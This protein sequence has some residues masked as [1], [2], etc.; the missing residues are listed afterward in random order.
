MR[1]LSIT[2]KNLHSLKGL[3]EIDLTR[4]SF[5]ESG[6]FLITGPTGAGK[7]T[8]LDALALA[9]Y[10]RAPRYSSKSPKEILSK[11]EKEGF[12]E[13][14]FQVKDK[15]Y[16]SRW[17]LQK[18][19][20]R[21]GEEEFET[22]MRIAELNGSPSSLPG[23][24]DITPEGKSSLVEKK[25]EE[26][27]G[28]N[29]ERFLRS[30]MLAQGQFAA[31]LKAKAKEKTELLSQISGVDIFRRLSMEAYRIYN[32]EIKVDYDNKKNKIEQLKQ[33]HPYSVEE[34][35]AQLKENEK[36][37]SKLSAS[38]KEA[39]EKLRLLEDIEKLEQEIR[40]LKMEK[41]KLMQEEEAIKALEAQLARSEQAFKAKAEMN[42]GAI[43]TLELEQ[44]TQLHNIKNLENQITANNAQLE[45]IDA[46]L[47]AAIGKA[48]NLEEQKKQKLP[49][50]EEAIRQDVE[51]HARQREYQDINKNCE[52]QRQE[53]EEKQRRTLKLQQ[54]CEKQAE[55]LDQLEASLNQNPQDSALYEQMNELE[56]VYEFYC[57]AQ[58][59]QQKLIQNQAQEENE[60][61]ALK[62]RQRQIKQ[63]MEFAKRQLE[64][65]QETIGNLKLEIENYT[66]GEEIIQFKDRLSKQQRFCLQGEALL[67]MAQ[68][69]RQSEQESQSAEQLRDKNNQ[70]LSALS[71]NLEKKRQELSVSKKEAEMAEKNYELSRN[72]KKYEADRALLKPGEPC[73]LCGSTEHPWATG[74]DIQPSEAETR[75]QFWRNKVAELEKEL[76]ELEIEDQILRVQ[77]QNQE[78]Q[79]AEKKSALQ[80]LRQEYETKLQELELEP[81]TDIAPEHWQNWLEKQKKD[82]E[83]LQEK[84]RKITTLSADLKK[85]QE[86][87]EKLIQDEN[88]LKDRLQALALESQERQG[89]LE[90]I[91]KDCEEAQ[92]E[93]LYQKQRLEEEIANFIALEKPLAELMQILQD[94]FQRYESLLKEK[95]T[96]SQ[97]HTQMQ[98]QLQIE[99]AALQERQKSLNSLEKEVNEKRQALI[100]QKE[101]RRQ[102][103]PSD[104]PEEDRKAIEKQQ[105]D[106]QKIV[107]ER[108][109]AL[110]RLKAETAEKQLQLEK[111][112]NRLQSLEEQ[113]LE[114]KRKASQALH[115]FDFQTYQELEAALLPDAEKQKM[116]Q[117][118]QDFHNRLQAQKGSS[119]QA[120]NKYR[121]ALEQAEKAGYST[122]NLNQSLLSLKQEKSDLETQIERLQAQKGEIMTLIK[123]REENQRTI[124]KEQQELDALTPR[125][126]T[127]G[128][129]CDVIGERQGAKFEKFVQQ[130]TLE[131]LCERANGY[132]ENL[133]PRYRLQRDLQE[134]TDLELEVIDLYQAENTRPTS[135]LSGGETFL[136]SLALSLALSDLGGSKMRIETL[137]IDEG[138]GTLDSDTL[139]TAIQTLENLQNDGKIIGLITHV[140]ELK[141]RIHT[142]INVQPLGGGVSKISIKE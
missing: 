32:D 29:Y 68:D 93:L 36:Q 47:E 52:N 126:R 34:L 22:K 108:R 103:W 128:V 102:I 123:Q 95:E 58:T 15:I 81:P 124:E 45:L 13:V 142:Q 87:R 10:G 11:S 101:K 139:D 72:I 30:V 117:K 78:D 51:I 130:I 76:K 104:T 131:Y 115:E 33:N 122:N 80:K 41:E 67:R 40:L 70:D 71:L 75:R 138:F 111:D 79:L 64:Q 66:Q 109:Q 8:I 7:S 90:V 17:E 121:T 2:L 63:E 127:L 53:L 98:N 119:E 60:L 114:L 16:R 6:I 43:H 55:A 105:E 48:Q 86:E 14:T 49:L 44:T 125:Y 77:I 84:D 28:L 69:Y 135:S 56:Q 133:N 35:Q 89:R 96:V 20:K 140:E 1:I 3:H 141:E 82:L 136:L 38:K 57:R 99:Q 12:A 132:L 94:R 100:E 129:I 39:E 46:E 137:F 116:E 9:L 42:L 134:Q 62:E 113:L 88:T 5:V 27:T 97:K 4:P 118:T 24:K 37:I 92:K 83:A 18:R 25:I 19:I 54:E 21:S 110:E 91:L 23:Q 106:V 59:R 73:F 61:A 112:R 26:L 31:F 50:I 85:N 107:N 74:L 65:K 120:Q